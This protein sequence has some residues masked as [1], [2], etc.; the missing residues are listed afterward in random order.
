VTIPA[1][2]GNA[3]G[4]KEMAAPAPAANAAAASCIC[5]EFLKKD[6]EIDRFFQY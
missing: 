1:T 4:F 6:P 3:P 2:V 5:L